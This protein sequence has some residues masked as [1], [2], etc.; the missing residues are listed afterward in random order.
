MNIM[1]C[2]FNDFFQ[3]CKKRPESSFKQIKSAYYLISKSANYFAF[4]D[5]IKLFFRIF[6]LKSD[7]KIIEK[8]S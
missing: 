8:Y 2:Y 3:Y 5:I 7:L 1:N 6:I 4:R